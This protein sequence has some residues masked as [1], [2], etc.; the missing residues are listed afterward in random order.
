MGYSS[1]SLKVSDDTVYVL[2]GAGTGNAI[3]KFSLN[4]DYIGKIPG[5]YN[6]P[7]EI[8]VGPRN[9]VF[10]SAFGAMG[11]NNL[12][13]PGLVLYNSSEE[14]FHGFHQNETGL[15]RPYGIHIVDNNGPSSRIA[16]C[17]WINNMTRILQVD[18][19]S[20]MVSTLPE[21]IIY[22][23]YPFSLVVDKE[24]VLIASTVCCEEFHEPLNKISLYGLDGVLIAEVQI[25]PT[26]ESFIDPHTVAVDP[27]G[28]YLVVDG[29][30]NKTM[31]FNPELEYLGLVPGI[32]SPNSITFYKDEMFTLV[33]ENSENP[34]Y[35]V[36]VYK[37]GY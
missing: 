20:G 17:D 5:W 27:A 33:M 36:K 25:L 16:V 19:D 7:M 6:W 34:E 13:R 30:L 8:V 9:Q 23:P 37:Y 4:G 26:G 21:P 1:A 11:D 32:V 2:N 24:K 22:T 35:F 15:G 28:N 10:L 29:V 3:V 12:L 18:W 14:Y 31:L